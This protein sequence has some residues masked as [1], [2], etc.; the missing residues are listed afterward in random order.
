MMDP[1]TG[2]F[3]PIPEGTAGAEPEER[4][5]LAVGQRIG[6]AG[7]VFRVRKITRHDVVLRAV[8]DESTGKVMRTDLT[9]GVRD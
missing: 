6:I 1:R 7:Y 8:V 3:E 5:T 2:E 9:K 4:L